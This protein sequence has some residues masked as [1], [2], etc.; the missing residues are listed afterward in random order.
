MVQRVAAVTDELD[1]DR[2]SRHVEQTARRVAPAEQTVHARAAPRCRREASRDA[3]VIRGDRAE[4]RRILNGRGEEQT[5]ARETAV[6]HRVGVAVVHDADVL[7]A[8]DEARGEALP[9]AVAV[10]AAD[11]RGQ[12]VEQLQ[13]AAEEQLHAVRLHERM[14]RA[15]GRVAPLQGRGAVRREHA[16]AG[17]R[18]RA[19][20]A[21]ER[22]G[23]LATGDD[24]VR[25]ARDRERE[26]LHR[27]VHADAAREEGQLHR[28]GE[29]GVARD[30]SAA[31]RGV[32][33]EEVD[34]V[35]EV[36]VELRLGEGKGVFADREHDLRDLHEVALEGGV[37]VVRR[38][39]HA[40]A[41]LDGGGGVAEDEGVGS[42]DRAIPWF[43]LLMRNVLW[44]G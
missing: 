39:R 22:G 35:G 1:V 13:L 23:R 10:E 38:L 25:G 42:H 2:H 17:D 6:R 29:E 5:V 18:G 30:A 20:D 41:G 34:L 32:V 9:R 8:R 24:D 14:R 28:V 7:V 33:R 11:V 21:V 12:L 40:E 43:F 37:E 26:G 27:E 3:E 31:V 19:N 44:G 16:G 4:G 15:P 36:L